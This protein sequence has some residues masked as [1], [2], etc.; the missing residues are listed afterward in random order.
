MVKKLPKEDINR[1]SGV[2]LLGS[3]FLIPARSK[4]N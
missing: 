1:S 4:N 3:L 2:N